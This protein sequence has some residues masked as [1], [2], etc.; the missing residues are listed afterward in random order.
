MNKD[1]LPQMPANIEVGSKV[2]CVDGSYTLSIINMT[3]ELKQ[4][5]LGMSNDIFTVVAINVP[6]PTGESGVEALIPHNN[7]IIVSDKGDIHFVSDM[8]ICNTKPL[9]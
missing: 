8:N 2:M 3:Q 6:C 1:K 5:T 4:I 7:C 9:F